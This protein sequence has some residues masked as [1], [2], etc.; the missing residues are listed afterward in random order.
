MK[1]DVVLVVPNGTVVD[2]V[3]VKSSRFNGGST[4]SNSLLLNL[5][6]FSEERRVEH[7]V[8]NQIQNL[9]EVC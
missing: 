1:S 2:F 3:A 5:K 7:L 8:P 9:V 6:E 4:P